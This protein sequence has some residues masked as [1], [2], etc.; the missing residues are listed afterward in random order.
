MTEHCFVQNGCLRMNDA[1]QGLVQ[2]WFCQ[3]NHLHNQYRASQFPE[4]VD[5]LERVKSLTLIRYPLVLVS[6]WTLGH[7]G[8][9]L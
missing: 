7:G 6:E 9:W 2:S 5:P 3:Q 1:N 8:S 4:F